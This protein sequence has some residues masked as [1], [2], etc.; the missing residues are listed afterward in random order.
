MSGLLEWPVIHFYTSCN[1]RSTL[2]SWLVRFRRII[3]VGAIAQQLWDDCETSVLSSALIGHDGR[4]EEEKGKGGEGTGGKKERKERRKAE[5]WFAIVERKLVYNTHRK[6]HPVSVSPSPPPAALSRLY[7]EPIYGC[8][9]LAV[10]KVNLCFA[11]GYP[12][13]FISV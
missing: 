2:F 10:V 3:S 7:G 5:K 12:F 1:I 8:I 13:G 11:H 9:G 4:I 6:I